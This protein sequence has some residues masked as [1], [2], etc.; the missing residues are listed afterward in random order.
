MTPPARTLLVRFPAG[1]YLG[2]RVSTGF[3]TDPFWRDR[4]LPRAAS[5]GALQRNRTTI[6]PSYK[7]VA[8]RDNCPILRRSSGELPRKCKSAIALQRYCNRLALMLCP[9]GGPTLQCELH[10]LLLALLPLVIERTFYTNTRSVEHV[11]V[12]HGR[13]HILVPLQILDSSD[14]VAVL[15]QMGGERTCL[16]TLALVVISQ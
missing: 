6:L 4:F 12:N 11:R 7:H 2:K 9:Y 3:R 16:Q 10:T 15:Q 13:A 8:G 5:I 1:T 14:V